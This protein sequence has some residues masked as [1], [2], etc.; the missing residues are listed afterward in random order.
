MP[1]YLSVYR[2]QCTTLCN[3]RA[4]AM[5]CCRSS[6]QRETP[7]LVYHLPVDSTTFGDDGMYSM[8]ARTLTNRTHK[9]TT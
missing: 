7:H 2:F 9:G 8:D 3:V 4:R 5:I 6:T 1:V